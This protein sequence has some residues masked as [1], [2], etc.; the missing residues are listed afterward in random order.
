[1]VRNHSSRR[2]LPR[3]AEIQNPHGNDVGYGDI[4][5]DRRVKKVLL[6]RIHAELSINIGCPNERINQ[7]IDRVAEAHAV[8]QLGQ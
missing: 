8:A 3:L 1:M 5:E 2:S 4:I 7:G 6:Q